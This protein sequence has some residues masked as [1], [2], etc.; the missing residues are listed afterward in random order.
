MFTFICWYSEY[1]TDFLGLDAEI[2]AANV[3]GAKYIIDKG[4][5]VYFFPEEEMEKLPS[6]IRYNPL[7][8]RYTTSAVEILP[9]SGWGEFIPVHVSN[10]DARISENWVIEKMKRAS[11]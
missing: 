4:G 10:F 2:L 8:L 9:K 7:M 1:S 11:A 5:R 6:D 3:K